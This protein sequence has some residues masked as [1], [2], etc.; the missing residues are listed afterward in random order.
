MN[1]ARRLEYIQEYYFSR[2]LKEVGHLISQG[3]P[4]VNLGIGSPD[5]MPPKSTIDS[6]IEALKSPLAHKY[7]SYNVINSLRQAIK[8]FYF[9][10]AS[11]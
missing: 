9:K 5:V 4:I 7:Q 1:T 8:S 11:S 6:L 3:K 10:R 2:K